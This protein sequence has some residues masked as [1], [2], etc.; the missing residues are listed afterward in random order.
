MSIKISFKRN[1]VPKYI[2][3]YVLFANQDFEINGLNK[4]SL[5][6]DSS[7]IQKVIKSSVLKKQ[8]F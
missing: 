1:I 8:E 6:K 4:L 3:N 5:K 2:K 7:F